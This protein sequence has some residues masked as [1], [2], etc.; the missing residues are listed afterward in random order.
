[1][2]LRYYFNCRFMILEIFHAK[3][4]NKFSFD[5]RQI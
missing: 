4:A 2:E 3:M 1:M 5:L